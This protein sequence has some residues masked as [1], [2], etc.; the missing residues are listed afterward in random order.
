MCIPHYLYGNSTK[1]VESNVRKSARKSIPFDKARMKP[2]P[3]FVD[4]RKNVVV[5]T[6]KSWLEK[7]LE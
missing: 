1:S 3:T 7:L 2:D 4:E 6:K 5:E